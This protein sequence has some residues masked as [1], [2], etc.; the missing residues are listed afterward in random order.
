[1]QN[2]TNKRRINGLIF[3]N[4]AFGRDGNYYGPVDSPRIF[5]AEV[6]YRF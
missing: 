6:G 1:M 3:D 5:G 2:L 4:L